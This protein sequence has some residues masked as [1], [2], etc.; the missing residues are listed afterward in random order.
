MKKSTKRI[1][2]Q[3][4]LSLLNPPA[5]IIPVG[6]QGELTLA[7]VELLMSAAQEDAKQDFQGG[8]D[9]REAHA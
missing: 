3:M 7:L 4:N 6:K 8:R 5:R 9:E 1:R 2:G